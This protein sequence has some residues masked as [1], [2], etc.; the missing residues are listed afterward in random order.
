[1][2]LKDSEQAILFYENIQ[3]IPSSN[4]HRL[5]FKKPFSNSGTFRSGLSGRA[6]ISGGLI[7][8]KKRQTLHFT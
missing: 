1:M 2:K 6:K 4:L 5:S 8:P 7:Q 3:L